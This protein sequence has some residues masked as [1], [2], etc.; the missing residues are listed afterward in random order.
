MRSMMKMTQSNNVTSHIGAVYI[1]NKIE[2]SW[3]IRQGVIYDENEI[4]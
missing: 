2:L 3:L 1:K 4:G